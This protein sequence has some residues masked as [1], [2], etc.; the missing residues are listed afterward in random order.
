MTAVTLQPLQHSPQ[1]L[2]HRSSN[3]A[4]GNSP[5]PRQLRQSRLSEP[6]VNGE[7]ARQQ[8]PP[9]YNS[10][11]GRAVMNG[12]SHGAQSRD[13]SPAPGQLRLSINSRST[14]LPPLHPSTIN[15]SSAV[16][17]APTSNG[18]MT[19]E[20][21]GADAVRPKSAQE[22]KANKMRTV[23]SAADFGHTTDASNGASIAVTKP[24]LLRTRSDFGPRHVQ[25]PVV[26]PDT[27]ESA[28]QIR[29]GWEEENSEEY[30]N[31][32][33]SVRLSQL[34]NSFA[35]AFTVLTSLVM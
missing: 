11:G 26:E 33:N 5:S 21:E 14:I 15:H 19:P 34:F 7:A 27:N 24:A 25:P 6:Q 18:T 3:T 20:D 22:S 31:L 35:M 17:E 29:H 30:L 32:M 12:Q 8:P 28:W 13:A 16:V 4:K 9:R 2:Q 1:T 10:E 23:A